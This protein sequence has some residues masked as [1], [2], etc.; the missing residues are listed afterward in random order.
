MPAKIEMSLDEYKAVENER[1]T[2][3]KEVARLRAELIDAKLNVVVEGSDTNVRK[4]VTLTRAL[5]DVTRFA[6][7]QLPPETHKGWPF[8]ALKT[9][10]DLLPVLPDHTVDDISIANEFRSFVKEGERVERVREEK[11]L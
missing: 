3:L 9:A 11:T 1:D 6:V 8:A 2:A 4:L 10:S 7:G 5:L